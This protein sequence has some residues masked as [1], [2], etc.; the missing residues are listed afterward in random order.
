M[1]EIGKALI[2]AE[3]GVNHNGDIKMAKKL[4]EAAAAAG[5][6]FV[7]FQTFSAERLVTLDTKKAEYQIDYNRKNESQFEMLKNLELS[8]KMHFELVDH[9][10]LHGIQFLSTGFDIESLNFLEEL[11]IDLIKIPS[12]EITNFPY[13]IHAGSLSKN[14]ILSTGMASL[15]EIEDALRV[16][17]S[18]GTNRKNIVV[19][20][21]STEYPTPMHDVNLKAMQNIGH[22]FSVNVGYSDH[23]SGIEIS[24]AAIAMGAVV[25]EKHFTLDRNL[26]GPDH[27][28]SLEPSELKKMIDAI[29][30]VEKAQGDG[31][32]RPS[33]VEFANRLIARK[34]LVASKVIQ[35]GE[36]F[37]LDNIAA[38]RSGGGMSP[39]RLNEVI[40]YKAT[41]YYD[42][43]EVI[44]L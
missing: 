15:G 28:A 14:I 36:E 29:R 25:I 17:E 22:A 30:N 19:L 41:R 20:H 7:K 42:V 35:Q 4:I 44:E 31:I 8:N 5:A 11:G 38:K 26:P 32:K 18:S 39:M 3:A 6:D 33:N 24:I 2:I 16:I 43:D 40:G 13:L 23:T 34:F 12:G 27:N 37:T 10:R 21:C 9:C 1:M